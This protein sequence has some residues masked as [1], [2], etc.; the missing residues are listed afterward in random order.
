MQEQAKKSIKSID[1]RKLTGRHPDSIRIGVPDP[2]DA[3]FEAISTDIEMVSKFG[4]TKTTTMFKG[5]SSRKE[6]WGPS[7]PQPDCLDVTKI[8]KAFWLPKAS[9]PKFNPQ[10]PGHSFSPVKKPF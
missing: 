5:M 7:K 6:L 9:P 8:D 10:V 1:L 3:R 2:N 4:N